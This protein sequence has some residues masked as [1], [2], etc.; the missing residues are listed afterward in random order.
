VIYFDQAAIA[1][2]L[3]KLV[4]VRKAF[5]DRL[6][7][8]YQKRVRDMFKTLGLI[9]PQYSGEFASNWYIV[10]DTPTPGAFQ[11]W[12]NKQIVSPIAGLRSPPKVLGDG[13]A[14]EFATGRA[15]TVQFTYRQKVYFVNSDPLEFT[16]TTVTDTSGET[17]QLRPSN[18]LTPPQM[19]FSYLK[20]RYAV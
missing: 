14:V 9:S 12:R 7:A 2:N 16:A 17:R 3:E 11:G 13:E 10:P 19:M 15:L 6:S 5:D 8:M 20:S 18:L 4:K 1:R